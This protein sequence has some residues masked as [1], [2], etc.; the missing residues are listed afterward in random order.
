MLDWLE[1][2]AV[3]QW[4]AGLS[5]W[6]YL[7]LSFAVYVA[8]GNLGAILRGPVAAQAPVSAPLRGSD[9]RRP[10]RGATDASNGQP[11]G[12]A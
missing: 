8:V 4:L 2:T 3:M 6:E 11:E 1:A 5:E 12:Q 10:Q 9:G 7:G